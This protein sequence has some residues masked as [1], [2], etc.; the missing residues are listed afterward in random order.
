MNHMNHI[1][2]YLKEIEKTLS[3]N[4]NKNMIN[5]ENTIEVIV[6][7]NGKIGIIHTA[8]SQDEEGQGLG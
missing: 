5:E 1:S 6:K 7:S 8:E 4:Q 3:E 2:I